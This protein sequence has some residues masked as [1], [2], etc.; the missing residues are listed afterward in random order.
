MR[1]KFAHTK[2]NIV[3]VKI[4]FALMKNNTINFALGKSIL[5]SKVGMAATKNLVAINPLLPNV[6]QMARLAK[7]LILIL[8]GIMISFL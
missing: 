7:I 2:N 8:E 3:L 1:I 4:H 6:P 5:R